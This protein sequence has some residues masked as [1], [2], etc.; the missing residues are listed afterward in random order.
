MATN[1]KNKPN[2]G[3]LVKKAHAVQRWSES[4]IDS[5]MKCQDPITGPAHF[6]NN[7]FF[8]QHPTQGMIQYKAFPYQDELLD[9]YHSNRFSIS[10]LGRQLGKC[11]SASTVIKLR[12][13]RTHQVVTMTVGEFYELQKSKFKPKGNLI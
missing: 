4:D 13:K 1:P 3:I 8:I 7:F 9:N 11:V 10:L 6:L 2:Q 12:N 5:L